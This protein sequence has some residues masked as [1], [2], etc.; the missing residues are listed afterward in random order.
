VS[1]F[2]GAPKRSSPSAEDLTSPRGAAWPPSSLLHCRSLPDGAPD[3]RLCCLSSQSKRVH[4]PHSHA[5]GRP[6]TPLARW[7]RNRGS[8]ELSPA[9]VADGKPPA[10]DPNR[11]AQDVRPKS[12]TR[13]RSLPLPKLVLS[14]QAGRDLEKTM[15]V[16]RETAPCG[17]PRPRHVAKTTDTRCRFRVGA[18][19]RK[20]VRP[21]NRSRGGQSRHDPTPVRPATIARRKSTGDSPKTHRPSK[22]ERFLGHLR[23]DSPTKVG[24]LAA[25]TTPFGAAFARRA[26]HEHLV[27]GVPSPKHRAG[28]L[29][30]G[31]L[32]AKSPLRGL[33]GRHVKSLPLAR[34]AARRGLTSRPMV[35]A[36]SHWRAP[37]LLLLPIAR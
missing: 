23:L 35:E 8:R 6:A 20:H 9:K 11:A 24:R 14:P 32:L 33:P 17:E 16:V 34:H 2:H 22:P 13:R 5:L 4:E 36:R 10:R 1:P 37:L 15:R 27:S 18:H 31:G 21:S 3:G 12:S 29:G 7:C 28:E 30:R 25:V 19:L 26:N